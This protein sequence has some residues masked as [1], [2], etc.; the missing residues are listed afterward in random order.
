MN[1]E[2]NPVNESTIQKRLIAAQLRVSTYNPTSN[3]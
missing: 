2:I 3:V 1:K